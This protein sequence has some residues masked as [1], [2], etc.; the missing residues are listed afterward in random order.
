M[1]RFTLALCLVVAIVTGVGL[2]VVRAHA[3]VHDCCGVA[4]ENFGI[5]GDVVCF[6]GC[7][8]CGL[9]VCEDAQC[10]ALGCGLGEGYIK[11]CIAP[12]YCNQIYACNP[13]D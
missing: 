4:Y 9:D 3:Q 7:N 5:E 13:C 10:D 6:S 8:V 11:T 2:G 1:G 12:D